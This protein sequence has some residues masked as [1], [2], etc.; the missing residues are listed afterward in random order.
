MRRFCYS[1]GALETE[2]GPLTEGLCQECF[3][4]DNPLLRVPGEISVRVCGQCGAYQID[5]EWRETESG[6]KDALP[7]AFK[8][9]VLSEL[10]V[11]QLTPTD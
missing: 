4:A 5:R 6:S 7:S 11:A 1:C 3:A 2:G 9:A 8:E 10:K